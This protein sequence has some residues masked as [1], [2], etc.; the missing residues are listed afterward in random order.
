MPRNK[1]AIL[2]EPALDNHI[3]Y[4]TMVYSAYKKYSTPSTL[5]VLLYDNS[6]K[7][8]EYFLEAL[9]NKYRLQNQNR[10]WF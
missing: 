1:Q 5:N 3:Q 8:D 7:T 6:Y 4:G 9:Y 10:I 2:I